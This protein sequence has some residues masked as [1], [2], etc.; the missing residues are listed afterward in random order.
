[1]A[2]T[3]SQFLSESDGV[4]RSAQLHAIINR[5]LPS[6]PAAAP[7]PEKPAPQLKLDPTKSYAKKTSLMD[8]AQPA[9]NTGDIKANNGDGDRAFGESFNP[10]D[11]V[12]FP[13]KGKMKS[14]LVVRH[15]KGDPHGSPFVVIDHGDYES[16]KVPEHMVR[17]TEGNAWA[18]HFHHSGPYRIGESSGKEENKKECPDCK[19]TG[20]RGDKIY[21]PR[22]YLCKTCEGT[23]K[24]KA[25]KSFKEYVVESMLKPTMGTCRPCQGTGKTHAFS[26]NKK[27][28]VEMGDVTCKNC[29]GSGKVKL[30]EAVLTELSKKTLGSYVKRAAADIQMSATRAG[31]HTAGRPTLANK[32]HDRTEKRLRGISKA[33]DR[34]SEDSKINYKTKS[35]LKPGEYK[36]APK[37]HPHSQPLWTAKNKKGKLGF[38]TNEESAKKHAL[39]EAR[40]STPLLHHPYHKKSDA[41]LHYIIKDAG[42]AAK[43]VQ[44]HDPKAE[45]KYLDQVNDAST[46]LGHRKRHPTTAPI[47]RHKLD[48]PKHGEAFRIA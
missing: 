36:E 42:E 22:A 41:E 43:A 19:G 44:S 48:N 16:A 2:K 12:S 35:E 45:A 10:G 23:G 5:A 34:L 47:E 30:G 21:G 15:D 27:G 17:K 8:D 37:I 28:E 26:S 39:K 6:K 32:E 24:Q 1:M 13:H 3:L 18:H 25:L 31:M 9:T 7:E 29:A 14:G 11:K 46:I 33:T 40:Y 4:I 38:F 20:R